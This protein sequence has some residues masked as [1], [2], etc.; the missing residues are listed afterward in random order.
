[1]KSYSNLSN[2]EIC[3]L[4][5]QGVDLYDL[6]TIDYPESWD[7]ESGFEEA[8]AQTILRSDTYEEISVPSKKTVAESFLV[9]I[10]LH[11]GRTYEVTKIPVAE[12]KDPE[13]QAADIFYHYYKKL[14]KRHFHIQKPIHRVFRTSIIDELFVERISG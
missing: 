10:R 11:N 1:M 2:A 12:D 5:D 9:K 3:E 6:I 14:N 7:F 13:E 4:L 8:Q